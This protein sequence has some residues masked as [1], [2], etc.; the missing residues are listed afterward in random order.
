MF[1]HGS[2]TTTTTKTEQYRS[3]ISLSLFLIDT[4]PFMLKALYVKIISIERHKL[5]SKTFHLFIPPGR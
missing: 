4:E 2:D 3:K 5:S 1:P